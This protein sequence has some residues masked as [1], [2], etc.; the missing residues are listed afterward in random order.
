MAKIGFFDSLL[1][2][3]RVPNTEVLPIFIAK[4]CTESS[5]YTSAYPTNPVH[6][7]AFL[8]LQRNER[9][10]NLFSGSHPTIPMSCGTEAV[11][12]VAITGFSVV[13]VRRPAILRIVIPGA[14]AQHAVRTHDC[15]PCR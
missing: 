15:C 6:S 1:R 8:S 3:S 5:R 4:K 7:V 2:F 9:D 10:N 14:A 13:T 11:R 12:V